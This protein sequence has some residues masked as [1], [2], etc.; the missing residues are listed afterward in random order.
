MLAGM[1]SVTAMVMGCGGGREDFIGE[2]VKDACGS[3]WPVCGEMAGCILGDESYTQGRFPG[4]GS[5]IVQVP[6]AAT[7]R[8]RFYLED[9]LAA[10]EQTVVTVHEEGCRARTRQAVSG[11]TVAESMEKF[12]E[13]TR[14]VDVTGV[15]DHLVEFESDMQAGYVL[16]V[17]VMPKRNR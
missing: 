15:G 8:V 1:L 5:F 6:E 14:D 4:R 17:E 3:S 10:G 2:R 16:K 12:G 13:F 7:V 9:V 11:R